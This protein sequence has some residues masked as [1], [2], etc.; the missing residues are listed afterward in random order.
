MIGFF[1][2]QYLKFKKN[3][4]INLVALA[5]VDGNIHEDEIAYLY[6]IGEIY[7]LKPHQIKKILENKEVMKPE[8]PEQHHQ[9]VALLYD[10]VGMM[11]A[12]NVIEPSEMAFCKKMFKE[13]GYEDLLI[14]EMISL[15]KTGVDDTDEWEVF[16]EKA[17]AFRLNLTDL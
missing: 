8:I 10:L 17:Q 1:E 6:K 15:T 2:Y 4:L 13:C 11:M 16:L 7:Q 9:K 12:D 5:A 3:H 14:D